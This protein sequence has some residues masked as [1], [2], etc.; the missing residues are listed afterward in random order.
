MLFGKQVI[1]SKKSKLIPWAYC[2]NNVLI[3]VKEKAKQLLDTS[4]K[5][6]DFIERIFQ[7][8]DQSRKT[9][10][11]PNKDPFGPRMELTGLADPMVRRSY[12]VGNAL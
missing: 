1:P 4:C 8:L 9:W 10:S 5:S 2:G 7:N 12:A 3:T 6:L 11:A